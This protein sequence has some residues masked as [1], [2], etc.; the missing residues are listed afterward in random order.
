MNLS[1]KSR[2][3]LRIGYN[4]NTPFLPYGDELT[5]NRGD[6]AGQIKLWIMNPLVTTGTV[7]D[8]IDLNV[9]ASAADNFQLSNRNEGYFAWTPQSY[10]SEKHGIEN[11]NDRPEEDEPAIQFAGTPTKRKPIEDEMHL[12]TFLSVPC[13]VKNTL[14]AVSSLGP[15][16]MSSFPTTVTTSDDLQ[17]KNYIDYWAQCFMFF[18]GSLRYHV[19]ISDKNTPSFY[20]MKIKAWQTNVGYNYTPT[21]AS[22][23]FFLDTYEQVY[24]TEIKPGAMFEVTYSSPYTKVF[25]SQKPGFSIS[26]QYLRTS[27]AYITY[28]TQ[29]PSQGYVR[30]MIAKS[31]GN[32]AKLSH[33][34]G[35]PERG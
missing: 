20:S 31:F 25:A 32:D 5:L 16:I 13:I 24:P 7:P 18:R 1:E 15:Y 19:F 3:T 27:N 33:W 8:N 2:F 29:N 21:P 34:V 9:Y 11:P 23:A 4:S 28:L 17:I 35:V 26:K 12:S 6:T 14:S 22:S 10:D 30:C